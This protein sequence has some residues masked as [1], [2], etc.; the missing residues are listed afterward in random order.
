MKK[1]KIVIILLCT[2]LLTSCQKPATDNSQIQNKFDQFVDSIPSQILDP[3]SPSLNQLFTDPNNVSLKPQLNV[4]P[5]YD[6]DKYKKELATMEQLKQELLSFNHSKL[7]SLQQETYD[8]LSLSLEKNYDFDDT[9]FFYLD[10]NPLG[11]YKGETS[12]AFLT[13]YFYNIR[14][15]FDIQS[16]INLVDTLPNYA[17][18][19]VNFE[20]QRQDNGYGLTPTEIKMSIDNLQKT[21]DINEFGFLSEAITKKINDLNIPSEIKDKYLKNI[22]SKLINNVYNFFV[23]CQ[24]GLKELNVLQKDNIVLGD[25]KHGKGYASYLIYI[26]TGFKDFNDYYDYIY[27]KYEENNK[28]LN[29]LLTNNPNLNLSGNPYTDIENPNELLS[30]LKKATQEDFHFTVDVKYNMV[31]LPEA[32]KSLM[33]GTGAFYY[34]SPL[35]DPHADQE[36][37]LN[38]AYSP[39]DFPTIAHEGYPGHMYQHVFSNNLRLPYI[40]NLLSTPDFTEGYA[41]YVEGIVTKYAKDPITAQINR[42]NEKS[43]YYL[44]LMIDGQLHFKLA[45]NAL[46]TLEVAFQDKETAIKI[47]HQLSF[48]PFVFAPYY[49]GGSLVEDM[50]ASVKNKVDLIKFNEEIIS[51]GN[52]P[53]NKL[54]DIINRKFK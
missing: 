4:W 5:D 38:N 12:N 52:L 41:N 37:M 34:I 50:Y 24:K 49:V 14:N 1:L 54:R 7:Q 10:N 22:N 35:D 9:A 19:M 46:E 51:H 33:P 31:Q 18:T 30:Y 32:F 44:L 2:I 39:A 26:N 21:I 48:T 20:Q 11:A 53:L 45:D 15:E 8:V 36:M 25:L 13:L 16:Y 17:Q 47:Y 40:R 43:V 3:A 23:S 28:E 6:I 27:K 42:L 29:S